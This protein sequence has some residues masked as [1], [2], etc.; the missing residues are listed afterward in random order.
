MEMDEGFLEINDLDW[1]A[2]CQDGLLAH[3]ATGGRG[4]VPLEVRE[5]ISVYENTYDYFF[6]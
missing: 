2:S 1:F 4:F 3:F 6:P 5:S